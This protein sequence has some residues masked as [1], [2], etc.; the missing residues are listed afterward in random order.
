MDGKVDV[1]TAGDEGLATVLEQDE[2]NVGKC[3]RGLIYCMP[4]A[5]FEP[6]HD[7]YTVHCLKSGKGPTD[8]SRQTRSVVW[9]TEYCISK[10]SM[11]YINP[12]LPI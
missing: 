5:L 8:C 1:T 9:E 12:L 7:R 4:R 11:K 10:S 2:G 3:V 6:S